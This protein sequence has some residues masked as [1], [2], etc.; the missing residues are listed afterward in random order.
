MRQKRNGAVADFAFCNSPLKQ[1]RYLSS[2]LTCADQATIDTSRHPHREYTGM[3]MNMPRKAVP[4]AL[5]SIYGIVYC[6]AVVRIMM[7]EAEVTVYFVQLFDRC[8]RF[9]NWGRMQG[10]RVTNI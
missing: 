7:S 9:L 6:G 4:Y 5:P 10:I 2:V 8:K 1:Q 3:P